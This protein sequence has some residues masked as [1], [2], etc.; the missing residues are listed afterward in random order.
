MASWRP[1]FPEPAPP[2]WV[3]FTARGAAGPVAV[4]SDAR[5]SRDERIWLARWLRA[6]APAAPGD[7]ESYVY[8]GLAAGWSARAPDGR[9]CADAVTGVGSGTEVDEPP[10]AVPSTVAVIW[11]GAIE[12]LERDAQ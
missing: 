10:G 7:E 8:L 9:V 2:H 3:C 12:A 11:R 4:A 1:R 6:H 5:L